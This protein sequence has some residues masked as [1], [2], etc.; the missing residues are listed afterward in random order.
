MMP[1]V[2]AVDP[3]LCYTEPMQA[4]P[5]HPASARQ[6]PHHHWLHIAVRPALLFPALALVLLGVIWMLTLTLIRSERIAAEREAVQSSEQQASTYEAL[7]VRAL[8][9]IDETLRVIQFA[10]ANAGEDYPR[11]LEDRGLLPPSLLFTVILTDASNNVVFSNREGGFEEYAL[12]DELAVLRR[13]D[14]LTISEPVPVTGHAEPVVTFG[15]RLGTTGGG[16]AGAAFVA[17]DIDYFVASFEAGDLGEDG[18]L[19]L[20]RNN[21]MAIAARS[22]EDVS[23]GEALNLAMLDFSEST[24]ENPVALSRT[25]A[26]DGVERFVAA[27]ELFE[28]PLTIVVG[29]SVQEV[30]APFRENRRLYLV[31]ASMASVVLATLLSLI[32][33][34]SHRLDVAR[35]EA[36]EAE[37][38]HSAQVEHLALHD[39]MTGLPNRVLFSQLVNQA[40]RQARREKTGLA[41]LFMDLD[42]FKDINDTLGHDAG[43]EMLKKTAARLRDCF[44]RSDTISRFGGDEF[45]AMMPDLTSREDAERVASKI[46]EALKKPFTLN[47][48]TRQVTS[49]VGIALFPEDGE[50]NETLLKKADIAMYGAKQGG[51]DRTMFFADLP[52]ERRSPG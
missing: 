3:W 27:V 40:I 21:G 44:R 18:L 20:V 14:I 32:G 30:L 25:D 33:Y 46:L 42:H 39:A 17:T 47:G 49:S 43:D 34:Q 52:P 31:S 6:D 19:A 8:G 28:F 15:R 12:E 41:V 4:P 11:T 48:E 38:A 7:M 10:H 45:V 16:F 2:S 50:D 23:S 9:E 22:G 26:L 24:V 29:L 1:P 5:R 36:L 13:S 35:K 37:R 51:R